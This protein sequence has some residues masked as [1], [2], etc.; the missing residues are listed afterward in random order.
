MAEAGASG[1]RKVLFSAQKNEGP[2][3]LEWIAYHK[4]IGFTD[5]VIVS[6]D[7]DDGSDD[8][9]DRLDEAGEIRHLRQTVPPGEAPQKHAATV[10]QAAGVFRDGD[11]VM[12][13]DADEFLLP[14]QGEG[15]LDDLIAAAGDADAVMVAWRFFGDGGNDTWPGRHVSARFTRAAQRWRGG[16]AQAKTLFRYGPRIER[17][18]IH[19]PVLA[20]GVGP[21][22]FRVITSHRAPADPKFFDRSRRNPFNR[23]PDAKGAYRLAQV[24][25]FSIR[26]PDMFA[27]KARRGDGYF[28]PEDNRVVRDDAFYRKK[29]FDAVEETGLL[30]H[31]AA[32]VAGM[33][34]LLAHPEVRRA[35]FAI[36][37]FHFPEWSEGQEPYPMPLRYWTGKK[38]FGDLI[39]PM[40]VA[41]LSG[42]TVRKETQGDTGPYLIAV[43]S[44]IQ[45]IDKPG[46][47]IWGAGLLRPIEPNWQARLKANPVARVAAVRGRLTRAELI[48]KVGL[49]VPEVYGDPALLLP[50]LYS[51]R[52]GGGG[53]VVCPHFRHRPYFAGVSAP[54]LTVVD[55]ADPPISVIRALATADVVLSSS[56][57]GLIV[58]QAY[59]VPWLWMQQ[60][61]KP[62][63]GSDFKFR[64]FFSTLDAPEVRYLAFGDTPLDA[65]AIREA[66]QAA[67]WFEPAVDL[68]ALAAALPAE[69]PAIPAGAGEPGASRAAL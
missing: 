9:L 56:L 23:V 51:F 55:V 29:D 17:L 66:S 31:E 2:F 65:G 39:S 49:D 46:A 44:M 50:R 35:C 15:R 7:C 42:R 59:G 10:A 43:G 6:N 11:W 57:H 18:D 38:N 3:L 32:T 36:P 61:E 8:L 14:T 52:R 24:A 25:H 67:A 60:D 40:L 26:T 12:W 13:L 47:V 27:L 33:K 20:E 41:G 22:E 21:A 69:A 62:L 64:D 16:G 63:D 54:G 30:R 4:A 58:A 34:R 45:T 68:D 5:V 37:H 48:A 53:I 28:A 19:R 1:G